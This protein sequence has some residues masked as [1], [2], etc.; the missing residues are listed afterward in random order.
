MGFWA[1][2]CTLNQRSVCWI[3][4]RSELECYCWYSF[5]AIKDWIILSITSCYSNTQ[6]KHYFW[7]RITEWLWLFE[8]SEWWLS[9]CCRCEKQRSWVFAQSFCTVTLCSPIMPRPITQQQPPQ[10]NSAA[11]N[12]SSQEVSELMFL[13][14]ECSEWAITPAFDNRWKY[15]ASEATT[16]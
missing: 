7:T 6:W 14:S 8:V 1:S 3:P 16:K 11:K 15:P 9:M 10:P 5:C 4:I 13:L 12:W 2:Q